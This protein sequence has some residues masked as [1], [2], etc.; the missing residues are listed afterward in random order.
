MCC[1]F[2]FSN[3]A[4]TDNRH[5]LVMLAP[6]V[7]TVNMEFGAGG[8]WMSQAFEQVSLAGGVACTPAA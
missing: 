4:S 2:A 5:E 1:V 3:D 8:Y 7:D 6:L